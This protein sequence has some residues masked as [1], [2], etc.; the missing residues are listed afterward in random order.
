MIPSWM[1][2]VTGAAVLMVCGVVTAFAQSVPSPSV[3]RMAAPPPAM[4]PL[5]RDVSAWPEEIPLS[6][7][8]APTLYSIGEPTNDEQLH[9]E[10]I[11]RARANPPAEGLRLAFTTDAE[12][13]SAIDFFVVDTNALVAAFNVIAPAPPLAMNAQLTLA[14]R[15]HSLDMFTNAFQE[16]VGSDG[17]TL[18]QRATAA[19]YLWTQLG[20]NIF[21]YAKSTWHG[22]AGFQIDWGFGPGGMQSPP[23]HR[24]TIHNAALH[25]VGIGIVTGLNTVGSV[26]VG[27]QVVTQD[28]GNGLTARPFLTG[29]VYYDLNGNN[30]YDAGEGLRGVRVDVSGA[31]HYAVSAGSGGFT[32]PANNGTRTVTFSGNGL[33]TT[34]RTVTFANNNNVKADLVLAYNAPVITGPASVSVNSS[35]L[36]SF[37]PVP[38]A[39]SYEL[40]SRRLQPYTAVEGAEGGTTNFT[41]AISPGYDPVVT[42]V[43]ASGAK[44][45]RLAMPVIEDQSL[46]L[47]RVL[48]PG[49]NGALVFASRLGW[50]T[51]TQMARVLVSTNEGL[52][53]VELWSHAGTGN[54]GQAIFS[55]VTNSLSAFT[56]RELVCRFLYDFTGG[57]GYPQT[58]TGIGWY[59]DDIAFL[60]TQEIAGTTTQTIAAGTNFV[61]SPSQTGSQVLRVRPLLGNN[62]G[63]SGPAWNVTVTPEVLAMQVTRI[64]SL[65]GNQ[66]RIEVRVLSGTVGT[67][68]L[69]RRNSFA[70]NWT[71]D[72]GATPTTATPGSVYRFTTTTSGSTQRFYRVRSQ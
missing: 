16:H 67:L 62:F 49:T 31:T 5:L 7:A 54:S 9:L 34:T 23:G 13:R 27:P 38:G 48:R 53:W 42:D 63:P 45:F 21:S 32:V 30:F 69:E 20:E 40:S 39:L 57:S 72:T 36:Y 15:R 17:R 35:N 3:P 70:D 28:F 58:T 43:W 47:N 60:D 59:L 64:E 50:A 56:G 6:A 8:A 2:F 41:V 12:V 24:N 25:E 29:V 66:V 10:L 65:A 55:R 26:T 33:P 14:A 61:F 18:G 22:H 68:A 51:S 71:T 37:S 52:S 44:A 11:N 46:T 4:P 19:G 1:R